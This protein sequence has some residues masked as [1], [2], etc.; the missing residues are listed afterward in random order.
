M[1][2]TWPPNPETVDALEQVIEQGLW[3]WVW[4][5]QVLEVSE[6][7]SE[8]W[9]RLAQE[10]WLTANFKEEIDAHD[11][12]KGETESKNRMSSGGDGGEGVAGGESGKDP[13]E[14]I[15]RLLLGCGDQS[16]DQYRLTPDQQDVFE[17]ATFSAIR[18]PK[19]SLATGRNARLIY[20]RLIEKGREQGLWDLC[21]PSY[22]VLISRPIPR[23]QLDNLGR[24]FEAREVRMSLLSAIRENPPWLAEHRLGVI[25]LSAMLWDGLLEKSAIE[26]LAQSI[27]RGLVRGPA[28][29]W[30]DLLLDPD[31][32]ARTRIRRFRPQ[33]L[34]TMLWLQYDGGAGSNKSAEQ[35]VRNL[36]KHLLMRE[37]SSLS[38]IIKFI[39][40]EIAVVIPELLVHVATGETPTHP[41]KAGRWHDIQGIGHPGADVP[42][43]DDVGRSGGSLVTSQL[44]VPE[45][46]KHSE[47]EPLLGLV[48]PPGMMK[49]REAMRE[50]SVRGMVKALERVLIDEASQPP[51]VN[52]LARW[53]KKPR[54]QVRASTRRWMFGL[55]GARLVSLCGGDD[56]KLYDDDELESLYVQVLQDGKS[57]SH[58][59]GMR[60]ALTSFHCYLSKGDP[61]KRPA[62]LKEL[63]R[64]DVSARVITHEEYYRVLEMLGKPGPT[65]DDPQWLMAC[66]IA[67]I[68]FF[69]LGM[70]RRELLWLPLHDI[71]GEHIIEILVRPFRERTL[72]T[73]NAIRTLMLNGFL[74]ESEFILVQTWLMRRRNEEMINPNGIYFFSLTHSDCE[75][76]SE[77]RIIKRIV[78]VLRTV[79]DDPDI[80]IHHLRHSFATWSVLSLVGDVVEEDFKSWSYLPETQQWLHSFPTVIKQYFRREA[81]QSGLVYLV[82]TLMGHS[83]PAITMEHYIHCMD[84]LLGS[85]LKTGFEI[86]SSDIGATGVGLPKRTYQRW[87]VKGWTGLLEVLAKRFPARWTD[88]ERKRI[89]TINNKSKTV[90]SIYDRYYKIWQALKW[91][92]NH[93]DLDP[94][95]TLAREVDGD[96]IAQLLKRA[97]ELEANGL[98]SKGYPSF[99]HGKK[100]EATTQ[101]YAKL[102]EKAMDSRVGKMVVERICECWQRYKIKGHSVLRFRD[103]FVAR[104][105]IDSLLTLGIPWAQINLT[106]VGSR[107]TKREERKYSVSWRKSMGLSRRISIDTK[108]IRNDRPLS[109]TEGY[110]EIRVVNDNSQQDGMKKQGSQEFQ[111]VIMMTLIDNGDMWG[112]DDVSI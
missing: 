7:E 83:T 75:I 11:A 95:G 52:Y 99:P 19:D 88:G 38:R 3:P 18:Q 9:L 62:L 96:E 74:S 100:R 90:G 86:E 93:G 59:I 105:Y 46:G 16:A 101:A 5:R 72:K 94:L 22:P 104:K 77:A 42:V 66:Q 49:L 84:Y 27:D 23:N 63:E 103:P 32:P 36:V 44:Q 70:R 30:L 54:K 56:P 64:S 87:S 28:G 112:D 48:N 73:S 4:S 29:F 91:L 14:R 20:M 71:H 58:R 106:W 97:V 76:I 25:L 10:V 92:D 89:K 65:D 35:A 111:W 45:V 102:F 24:L 109:G 47:D 33:A 31:K 108:S 26:A 51:V 39:A 81:P 82:A 55:V 69:R 50:H 57:S 85:A 53:L 80:H 34:T 6:D 78:E 12:D 8:I 61:I 13:D 41:I 2:T 107:F 17:Q 67:M 43:M 98:L 40:Q 21:L 37:P 15:A 79:T 110:M 1:D 60:Y 68:L